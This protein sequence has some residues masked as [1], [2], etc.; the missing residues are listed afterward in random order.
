MH[1]LYGVHHAGEDATTLILEEAE[2]DA[3]IQEIEAIL[4]EINKRQQAQRGKAVGGLSTFRQLKDERQ[5][6]Q[7]KRALAQLHRNLEAAAKTYN[8]MLHQV[9]HLQEL[10]EM[11][12]AQEEELARENEARYEEAL[13]EELAREEHEKEEEEKLEELEIEE[14]EMH[15][16]E[17]EAIYTEMRHAKEIEEIEEAERSAEGEKVDNKTREETGFESMSKKELY[18]KL[19][20]N[21]DELSE[22][23]HPTKTGDQK[24]KP[25]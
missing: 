13:G 19:E 25:G 20:K 9:E 18:A 6:K 8:N 12:R 21:L 15:M 1:I 3:K 24:T 17:E 10:V 4:A 5:V 14:Q 11:D 16:I 23:S 2:W 7:I 22:M